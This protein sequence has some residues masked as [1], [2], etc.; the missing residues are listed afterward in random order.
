MNDFN[1]KP[2]HDTTKLAAYLSGF[3]AATMDREDDPT[4]DTD[5]HVISGSIINRPES[6][7]STAPVRVRIGHGVAAST[8]AA[9]LRKMADMLEQTP[10]FLSEKPGFAVRR[11]PDG[12]TMTKQLT[13]ENM[14]AVAQSLP[15]DERDRFYAMLDQ[16]RIQ[17]DDHDTGKSDPNDLMY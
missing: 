13:I 4:A 15:K 1:Q 14:K 11:L 6:E 3:N 10:E 16:I 17:I 2:T 12:S 5:G 9:M 7:S 8:A